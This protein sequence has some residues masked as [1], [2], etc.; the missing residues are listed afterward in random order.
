MPPMGTYHLAVCCTLTNLNDEAYDLVSRVV[1]GRSV[2]HF[3]PMM[4]LS[5]QGAEVDHV[6]SSPQKDSKIVVR[7]L[8]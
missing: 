2:G 5:N 7:Y 4:L 3:R 1:R 8:F 6:I